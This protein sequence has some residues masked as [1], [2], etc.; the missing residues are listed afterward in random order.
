MT[1]GVPVMQIAA[2]RSRVTMGVGAR[3]NGLGSPADE[4]DAVP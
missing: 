1:A 3:N 2:S 4:G